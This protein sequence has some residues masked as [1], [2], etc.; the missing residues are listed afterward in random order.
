MF[1][2]LPRTKKDTNGKNTAKNMIENTVPANNGG[3]E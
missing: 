3:D 1:S 2:I